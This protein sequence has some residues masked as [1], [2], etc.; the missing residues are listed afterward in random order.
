[1]HVENRRN[2]RR[3]SS[4]AATLLNLGHVG[5]VRPVMSLAAADVSL[6]VALRYY[7][8]RH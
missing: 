3:D 6:S 5:P 2:C 7:V 1:M 8:R 4:G